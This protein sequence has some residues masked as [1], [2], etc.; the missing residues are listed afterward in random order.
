MPVDNTLVNLKWKKTHPDDKLTGSWHDTKR[1]I[2]VLKTIFLI[3][4]FPDILEK[5]R[6]VFQF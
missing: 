5:T 1:F 6:N 2:L 4:F 3:L